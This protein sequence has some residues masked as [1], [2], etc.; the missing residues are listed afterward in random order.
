MAVNVL[1][2]TYNHQHVSVVFA[3]IVRVS[4]VNPD[5]KNISLHS[6][7][8]THSVF[9]VFLTVHHSIDLFPLPN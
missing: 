1:I 5:T 3:T 6:M 2:H 7:K 4:E 8:Q 9:Y